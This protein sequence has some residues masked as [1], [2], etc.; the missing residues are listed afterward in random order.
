MEDF[1]RA[2]RREKKTTRADRVMFVLEECKKQD[3]ELNL[4]TQEEGFISLGDGK[5]FF[6]AE[7]T[8]PETESMDLKE[9]LYVT[10]KR[11]K[12]G[13]R[14]FMETGAETLILHVTPRQGYWR[15]LKEV[16]DENPESAPGLARLLSDG[17]L[18]DDRLR[19]KTAWL[20]DGKR[21]AAVASALE[22]EYE[23]L[24]AIKGVPLREERIGPESESDILRAIRIG[25][26]FVSAI[27]DGGDMEKLG[28]TV[29]FFAGQTAVCFRYDSP[30]I[31]SL[32]EISR[33]KS[34]GLES[35]KFFS[36][37]RGADIGFGMGA[38]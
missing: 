17:Y 2:E 7:I 9:P 23:K 11:I 21:G 16:V 22:R 1:K 5:R 8:G 34:L 29:G 6:H 13:I 36:S 37:Q 20:L 31:S 10:S 15:A 26:E 35:E 18:P 4:E 27:K 30:L 12:R 24:G 38:Y 14:R 3:A 25:Q 19:K 33:D 28:A 32:K